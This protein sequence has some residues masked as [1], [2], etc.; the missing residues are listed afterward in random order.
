MWPIDLDALRRCRD[1]SVDPVQSIECLC[2]TVDAQSIRRCA[3]LGP[4]VAYSGNGCGTVQHRQYSSRTGG[5]GRKAAEPRGVFCGPQCDRP[6]WALSAALYQ[7][8]Q[9]AAG[10][11][12]QPGQGWRTGGKGCARE[13]YSEYSRPRQAKGH[14]LIK[15]ND[16]LRDVRRALPD[17]R[18]AKQ[19][20]EL[21]VL[22]EVFQPLHDSA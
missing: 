22:G 2:S 18:L 14:C 12:S 11:A 16:S 1:L 17:K 13:G 21:A 3:Q 15:R 10:E 6:Q 19:P 9:R 8:M 5:G 7:A 4:P 20:Q